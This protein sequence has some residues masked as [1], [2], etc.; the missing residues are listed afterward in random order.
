MPYWALPASDILRAFAGSAGAPTT[1]R[2]FAE[3]VAEARRRFV[4]DATWLK[5]DPVA[6]TGDTPVPFDLRTVWHELD[7]E[8]RE[9]LLLSGDPAQTDPGDP[10][11]LTPAEYTPHGPGNTPPNQG[12]YFGSHGRTPELLRLGLVDPRLRFLREPEG[13]LGG[14][15]PLVGAVQEWLGGTR[16]VSVLDFS[17]VPDE[18]AELAICVVL[19]LLF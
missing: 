11:T 14:P 15:D 8:N 16:P 17:G 5:L 2:R 3:L 18:A 13:D 10:L 19:H 6:V 9:T 12:P 7:G 4:Q 1:V